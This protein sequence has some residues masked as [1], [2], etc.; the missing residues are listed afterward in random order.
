MNN[1]CKAIKKIK[2]FTLINYKRKTF[3][4]HATTIFSS[5]T[6]K[7]HK[8]SIKNFSSSSITKFSPTK[9]SSIV[10][11][12]KSRLRISNLFGQNWTDYIGEILVFNGWVKNIRLQGGG[13]FMFIDLNDG[14]CIFNIQLIIDKSI[15]N[16]ELLLAEGL[17]TCLKVKGQVVKSQG[18]KQ[19]VTIIR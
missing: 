9:Y 13:Q 1:I 8:Q 15:N 5:I 3:T 18:T 16:F 12:L 14:S 19:N 11:G 7:L 4:S 10:E 2:R 17:G 6:P